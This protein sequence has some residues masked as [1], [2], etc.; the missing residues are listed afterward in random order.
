MIAKWSEEKQKELVSLFDT[1]FWV[2]KEG[3]WVVKEWFWV[4]K[5]GFWVVKEGFWVVKE[6]FW[7]VKEGFWVVK[8]GFWVV[9]EGFWVVKEW[10][11]VVKE[12]FWVVKEGFWVVKEVFWVV[13]EGFWVVK[14]GF[15]VVKEWFWVVKEG[16]WVVKEGFWVVKE[17]FWVVKEGLAFSK[18]QPLIELQEKNSLSL[19]KNYHNIM[20]CK[21]FVRSIAG[22]ISHSLDNDLESARFVSYLSDGSTDSGIIEQEIIYTRYVKNG[23]VCTRFAGIA[24]T[25]TVDSPGLLETIETVLGEHISEDKVY[26]KV[27][28]GASVMSGDISGVRTLMKGKQP[29]LANTHCVAHKLEL[30]VT[31]SNKSDDVFKK[32]QETTGDIF[33]VYYKSPK[34]RREIKDLCWTKLSNSLEV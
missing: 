19:G 34:K 27:V 2:V 1:A 26:S 7:V 15:W 30:C 29:G 28:N 16:F 17:G 33:I 9:K 25:K 22:S 10:F 31:D 3:F 6:V 14:E 21:M 8:E 24:E 23:E 20:C 11:W 32:M 18:F 5:E 12:G 4:V 13:K